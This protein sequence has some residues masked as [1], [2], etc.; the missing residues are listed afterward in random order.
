MSI[1]RGVILAVGLT[2]LA[3]CASKPMTDPAPQAQSSA[4]P[5]AADAGLPVVPLTRKGV[6]VPSDVK[7]EPLRPAAQ[8][9]PG[10]AGV[11]A[12]PNSN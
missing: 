4:D 9:T 1:G 11:T 6:I 2:L 5:S 10:P 12:T 3:A 8:T 7:L